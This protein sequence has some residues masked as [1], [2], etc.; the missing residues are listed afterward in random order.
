ME[1]EVSN[2]ERD[3]E[4]D[5]ILQSALLGSS[6]SFLRSG[7]FDIDH[8]SEI[9]ERIGVANPA[10][11]I[12]GRPTKVIDL[13]KG[14]TG[15]ECEIFKSRD[16]VHDPKLHKYDMLWDSLNTE[17]SVRWLASIY[18]FPME[19]MVE[20]CREKVCDKNA[21]RFLVKGIDWRSV[22]F[23]RNPVNTAIEG[24]AQVVSAKS[25]MDELIK[26]G[27]EGKTLTTP[28]D[29]AIQEG[30][31]VASPVAY[32][33]SIPANMDELVGQYHRHMAKC[34][35]SAGI[36]SLPFYRDHFVNCCGADPHHA[37]MLGAA[38]MYHHINSMIPL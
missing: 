20:D 29:L 19:G 26:C 22:A 36:N 12:V 23:T 31:D 7:H 5:V 10:S 14:R 38:L 33:L 4:D 2:E 6:A 16:G 17:P 37:E 11:Y 24:F 1:L 32:A 21:G 34:P 9:G 30:A 8:I 25:Y 35:F 3:G 28:P 18:G 13:G 27:Y 15:C